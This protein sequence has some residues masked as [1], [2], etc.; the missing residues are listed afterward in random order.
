MSHTIKVSL[1]STI[2]ELF[3]LIYFKR[4]TLLTPWLLNQLIYFNNVWET[5]KSD[6]DGV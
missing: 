2:F 4:G 5:Y 3:P 6:H 1:P